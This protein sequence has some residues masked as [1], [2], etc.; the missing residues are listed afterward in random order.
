M[1]STRCG[2]LFFLFRARDRVS[3]R[4]I[5]DRILQQRAKRATAEQMTRFHTDEY[6]HFLKRVTP[7][8]ADELTYHGTR[9]E[10]PPQ[11]PRLQW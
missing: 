8:T 6:V 4:T 10:Y 7:E 3:T 1:I 11:L 5:N 9:C 2:E